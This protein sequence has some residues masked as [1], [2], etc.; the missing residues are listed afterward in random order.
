MLCIVLPVAAAAA[1]NVTKSFRS[2]PYDGG[3]SLTCSARLRFRAASRAAFFLSDFFLRACRAGLPPLFMRANLS[4]RHGGAQHRI[5]DLRRLALSSITARKAR[6]HELLKRCPPSRP[7]EAPLVH[8]ASSR[9]GST[10]QG[11]S[12]DF[13][14]EL[15][16]PR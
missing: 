15:K 3:S 13:F 12:G 4:W 16:P 1:S 11:G 7:R 10:H 6:L 5:V 8:A 14:P 2:I 9:L